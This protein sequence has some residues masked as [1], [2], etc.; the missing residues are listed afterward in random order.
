MKRTNL[1]GNLTPADVPIKTKAFS[2]DFNL[3]LTPEKTKMGNIYSL[4]GDD[5]I[6]RGY[7]S[8]VVDGESIWLEIP[9]HLLSTHKLLK[10][11]HPRSNHRAEPRPDRKPGKHRKPSSTLYSMNIG[12]ET[13]NV[14]Q[15]KS[16]QSLDKTFEKC[17]L[18]M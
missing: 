8:V 11:Y 1:L 4:V 14:N 3:P 15:S 13:S 10:N 16:R 7:D 2:D 18:P 17:P 12:T 6:A 5:L 9:E